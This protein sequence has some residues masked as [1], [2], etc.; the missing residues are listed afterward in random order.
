MDPES[1]GDVQMIRR[2]LI[3]L[4]L[5]AAGSFVALAQQEEVLQE[6]DI[7]F[8]PD[9]VT[10]KTVPCNDYWMVGV[11][12]GSTFNYGYFNPSRYT[13]WQATY[14]LVG[15][16]FIRYYTMFN[17]FHIMGLE[18]GAQLN[19]EG[20]EFK[21]NKET[22][23]HFATESGAY[24]IAMTVPEVFF[25]THFHGDISEHF[26]AMVKLGIYGGYRM[27]IKRVLD[28]EY[29]KYEVYQQYVN[30]FRDYDRRATYGV[31]GGIGVGFMFDPIEIH[32]MAQGKW[33]WGSYWDPG[34]ASKWY[35]RFGYPLDAGIT[36]G[37]YYQLTP[38]FGHT[39][40]QLRKLAKKIVENENLNGNGRQ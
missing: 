11:Y 27:D 17:M 8:I 31:L 6:S 34:Y 14:P 32:I 40:S 3:S 36:I 20:Y 26:K 7:F 37:V 29:A 38:R 22:G 21:L 10:V 28:D 1:G 15:F 33:G 9:T 25:L 24:K 19:H 5:F 18:F 4:A 23:R 13:R 30:T 12:G 2:L 16:S 39:R 35:Y